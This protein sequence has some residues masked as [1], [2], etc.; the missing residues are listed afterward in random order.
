MEI[1]PDFE[2]AL[3]IHA[4]DPKLKSDLRLIFD[5]KDISASDNF[6]GGEEIAAF[7]TYAKEVLV[8]ILGF[9]SSN[10]KRIRSAKLTIGKEEISIQ[11]YDA[12]DVQKLMA[13]NGFKNALKAM[14]TND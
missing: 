1:E 10:E 2:M 5:A 7:F 8:K 4:N 6:I 13:S 14:K 9:V 11:G 3:I 12:D